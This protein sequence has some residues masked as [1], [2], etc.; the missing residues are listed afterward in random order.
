M[1]DS[2]HKKKSKPKYAIEGGQGANSA[3]YLQIKK[4]R[5]QFNVL[6]SE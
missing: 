1:I 6:S 4:L 2:R 3:T 5:D